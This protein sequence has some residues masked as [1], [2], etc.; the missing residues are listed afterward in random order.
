MP[1]YGQPN[2][3]ARSGL[4]YGLV[5]PRFHV[6]RFRGS[7]YPYI[8]P[9]PYEIGPEEM[10]DDEESADAIAKKTMAY[11]TLDPFAI[12]KTNPFY[13][14]AGNLKLSV[15][16]WRTD[17]VLAEINSMGTSM[18]PIPQLHRGPRVNLGHS[19]SGDLH[20]QYLTPGNFR[21]TGTLSGWSHEP[22]PNSI[23]DDLDDD[24]I[25]SLEDF[26]KTALRVE[27]E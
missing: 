20:A 26:I 9:D 22:E 15:C 25:Y 27:P 19:M 21:R 13:F 5:E 3:D 17:K 4:G 14:G 24:H 8:E 7:S 6:S 10:D 18:S 12:N 16:F 23:D 11:T 2:I 1:Y